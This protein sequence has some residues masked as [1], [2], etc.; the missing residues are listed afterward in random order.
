M[1]K[2]NIT[3][4]NFF[5]LRA[6]EADPDLY[7]SIVSE[8]DRQRTH[9]ELIASGKYCIAGLYLTYKAQY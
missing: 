8:L 4:N 3:L 1:S 7:S 2:E 5:K 6:E 9:L